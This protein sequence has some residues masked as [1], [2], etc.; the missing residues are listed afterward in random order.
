M[1]AT[2]SGV[3][4]SFMVWIA[5]LVLV[6]RSATVTYQSMIEDSFI[7]LHNIVRQ[8]VFISAVT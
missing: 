1:G 6:C 3:A 4:V 8:T 5:G 7:A 2:H